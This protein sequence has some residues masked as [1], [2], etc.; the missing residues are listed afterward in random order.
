MD[1]VPLLHEDCCLLNIVHFTYLKKKS[2]L[3]LYSYSLVSDKNQL[4]SKTVPNKINK[5]VF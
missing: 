4:R 5:P 3:V 1:L 2:H